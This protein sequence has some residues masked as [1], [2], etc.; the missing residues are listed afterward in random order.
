[1]EKFSTDVTDQ[2]QCVNGSAST[3]C[4]GLLDF[5]EVSYIGVKL[6]CKQDKVCIDS[7]VGHDDQ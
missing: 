5:C 4:Y 7:I 6:I 2:F 1:M 3:F